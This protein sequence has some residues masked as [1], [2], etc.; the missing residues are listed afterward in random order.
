MERAIPRNYITSTLTIYEIIVIIAGLL[1]KTLN[2]INF[3]R[4]IIYAINSLRGLSLEPLESN[5]MINALNFMEN[6]I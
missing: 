6:M 4:N 2:G 1:G 5:D 3:I